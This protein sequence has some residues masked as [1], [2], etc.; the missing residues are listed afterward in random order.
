[1][2]QE[3]VSMIFLGCVSFIVQNRLAVE[4]MQNQKRIR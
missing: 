2:L 1:M 4:K 3:L